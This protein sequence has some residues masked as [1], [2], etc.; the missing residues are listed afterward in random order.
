MII[1]IREGRFFK[2]RLN[3][4]RE[5]PNEAMVIVDGLTSDLLI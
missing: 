2:G 5:D 3:I 1:G 4:S